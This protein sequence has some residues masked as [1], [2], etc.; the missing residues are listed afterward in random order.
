MKY[1]MDCIDEF[2][3]CNKLDPYTVVMMRV[4]G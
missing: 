2:A 3:E 1:I 4:F